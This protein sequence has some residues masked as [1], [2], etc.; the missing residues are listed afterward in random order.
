MKRNSFFYF[1]VILLVAV[2][3]ALSGCVPN[4]LPSGRETAGGQTE[5]GNEQ[6]ADGGGQTGNG[7]G[8]TAD[9]G[10][11][12]G[13]G[14]TD[15][16]GG[17]T[18]T[19]DGGRGFF[20]GVRSAGVAVGGKEYPLYDLDGIDK[21]EVRVTAV[22]QADG[23]E[24]GGRLNA[25]GEF[26]ADLPVG[27]Y[28]VRY[29][30]GGNVY[31]DRN[32]AVVEGQRTEYAGRVS[33]AALG[34]TVVAPRTGGGAA[35]D[36]SFQAGSDLAD[37]G[38][39]WN[40]LGGR[41]DAV[42][43]ETY[44]Y[45]YQH[46]VV[47]DRYYVETVLD[48]AEYRP[49]G[50]VIYGQYIAGLL[51]SH[52][53]D[54]LSGVNPYSFKIIASVID[55]KLC[56]AFT[57]AGWGVSGM[58]AA[59]ELSGIATGAEPVKLGAVR[60]GTAYY[61]FVNG[62]FVH[63]F[64]YAHITGASGFGIAG[65]L[66]AAEFTG[67]NYSARPETVDALTEYAEASIRAKSG[68]ALRDIDV[69]LIA[70]QSNAAGYSGFEPIRGALLD[71]N[72]NN[73][74]GFGG[75]Y[76]YGRGISNANAAADNATDTGGILQL[77][78]AGLGNTGNHIGPELGMANALSEVYGDK[79]VGL[80]KLASGGTSL[81]DNIDGENARDGNWCPPSYTEAAAIAPKSP[82]LTGGLYRLL[83]RTVGDAARAYRGAGFRIRV[84]GLYWM[85]GESNRGNA[86]LYRAT[87]K[88]FV[89][90]IRK[91]LSVVTGE[92]L[93]GMPFFIGEIS[94]TYFSA[95]AETVAANEAFIRMQNALAAECPNA[96]IVRS[97]GYDVNRWVGGGDQV[98]GSDRHHWSGA[99]AFA[100][101]KLV[102]RAMAE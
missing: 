5:A 59:A 18:E 14:Q 96:Y 70:G 97:S 15:N 8:Q 4:A 36:R 25:A 44:T 71:D 94:R 34:G 13:N 69:Y 41:R 91:D 31:E 21:A 52:G 87:M 10:G 23:S 75:V 2:F 85:Q 39:N 49:V 24:I 16:G 98:V 99:D 88:V 74:T 81:F 12:V 102:G 17:Q 45:V 19:A 90:D 64:S 89:A 62:V 95:A 51:L 65:S 42:R 54:S 1:I 66:A 92:N 80:I 33:L 29:E 83:L 46:Q 7:N 43:V 93:S 27:A 9:G 57:G 47:G 55:N 82:E 11:Q 79:P 78:K 48:P 38:G 68:G 28:T 100:I 60:D 53:P 22:N 76:Y 58:V 72:K 101:G 20:A 77:A 32:V 26:T 30:Y 63:R 61:L 6:T 84:K 50:G 35:A 86:A 3:T 40:L 56:Y 67:F 73:L 37:A